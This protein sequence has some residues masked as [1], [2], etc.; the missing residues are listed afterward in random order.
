MMN[1]SQ[2]GVNKIKK[3][4]ALRLEAY[5]D[6]GGLW[7]IGYGH[8]DGGRGVAPGLTISEAEA[9]Q[10]LR[11]DLRDAESAVNNMVDERLTQSQYDALVSFVFNVGS[12]AFYT[13]TLRKKVNQ[14]PN[15]AGIYHEFM[16]WVNAGGQESSGLVKRRRAEAELYFGE[17]KKLILISL[18]VLVVIALSIWYLHREKIIKL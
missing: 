3:W 10:L 1:I 8:T 13:S 4:E 16:R 14:D 9:E 15:Q 17:K 11:K 7:T 2:R 5:Q 6:Q 18:G 12:G